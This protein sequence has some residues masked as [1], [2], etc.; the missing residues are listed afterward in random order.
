MKECINLKIYFVRLNGIVKATRSR[1]FCMR[2]VLLTEHL[3]NEFN[4]K[5][6]LVELRFPGIRETIMRRHINL[7]CL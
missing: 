4:Y 6:R 3:R 1:F 5:M 7:T 2:D